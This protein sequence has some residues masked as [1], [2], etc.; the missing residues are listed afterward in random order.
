MSSNSASSNTTAGTERRKPDHE[1]ENVRGA[2]LGESILAHLRW[3]LTEDHPRLMKTLEDV[4]QLAHRGSF[5]TAAK[6]FGEFRIAEER[7][8]N[9]EDS[10]LFPIIERLSGPS[11]TVRQGRAD[12]ETIRRLLDAV[13]GSLSRVTLDEFV[14]AHRRLLVALLE[15]WEH[16]ERLL[17]LE[18]K[19][20]DR[21]TVEEIAG[22]LQRF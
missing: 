13:S 3:C 5:I 10:A 9:L 14:H 15:H 4:A 22:A 2:A 11:Q 7:H 18:L 1:R 21:E 20:P 16:E 12:H 17:T 6:R 19:I 8:M